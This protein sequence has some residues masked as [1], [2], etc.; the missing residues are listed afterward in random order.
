ME[1]SFGSASLSWRKGKTLLNQFAAAAEAIRGTS[2]GYNTVA[3]GKG[4]V[5]VEMRVLKFLDL[6]VNDG[7]TSGKNITLIVA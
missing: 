3:E 4:G 1:G 7:C 6:S 5:G 2:N